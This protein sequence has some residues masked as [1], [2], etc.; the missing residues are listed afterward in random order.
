MRVLRQ[1]TAGPPVAKDH[2]LLHG[3]PVNGA[4]SDREV[5]E[6]RCCKTL[7]RTRRMIPR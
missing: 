5:I 6:R 7:K 4:E 3:S 2:R 1:A